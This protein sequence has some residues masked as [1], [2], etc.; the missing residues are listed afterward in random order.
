MIILC[1]DGEKY[2]KCSHPAMNE[3]EEGDIMWLEEGSSQHQALLNI[4]NDT[5]VLGDLQRLNHFCH[6]GS[7]ENFHSVLLKWC[8]KRIHYYF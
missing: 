7:L 4:V 3:E 6:T 2:L 5:K 1:A 8:P